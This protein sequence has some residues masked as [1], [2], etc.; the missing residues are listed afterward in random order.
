M[1]SIGEVSVIRD[2]DTVAADHDN[3]AWDGVRLSLMALRPDIG[4]LHQRRTK[5]GD[6]R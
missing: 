6:D 4:L 3:D 2:D 1:G 5:M